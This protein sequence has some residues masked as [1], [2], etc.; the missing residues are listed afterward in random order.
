MGHGLESEHSNGLLVL[1]HPDLYGSPDVPP[2]HWHVKEPG[3]FSQIAPDGHGF[4]VHSSMSIQPDMEPVNPE[5]HK[6]TASWLTNVH[7][8][9]GLHTFVSHG[10]VDKVYVK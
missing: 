5:L 3:T 8:S 6:H 7:S 10:S 9:F 4:S 1:E 2:G